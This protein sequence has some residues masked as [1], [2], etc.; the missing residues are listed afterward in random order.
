[1]NLWQ[2]RRHWDALARVDPYF[3]VLTD[4]GKQGN[5]WASDEFFRTGVAEADSDMARIR[6]LAPDLPLRHALDFGCGAGRLTQG[7]ARHFARVTGVDISGRM[8]DLA[9]EQN[10][11]ARVA[12]VHN[13]RPDL[14]AFGDNS[15]DL[16]CSRITLQHI[17][18]RYTRRYLREFVRVLSPGGVMLAQ[19]PA[20]V[21]AGDPPERLRFSFWPPT[22]WM[23]TKRYV[24]Y[25]RP[26]WFSGTPKMQ[27]YAVPRE[28]VL[29]WLAAAGA[30]V[31]S[32]ERDEH[33]G[34]ENL[35]YIARKRG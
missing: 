2:L 8:V 11:D 21:P 35:T 16:V 31:L 18:P 25:H 9:R 1:M 29:G 19:V 5:R 26:G 3:A 6:Q 22:L 12:F 17:A 32:V 13:P 20:R 7:L 27:M 4:S 34:L 30:E 23:R 10:H 33:E 14:R 24:R 15:F 28:E